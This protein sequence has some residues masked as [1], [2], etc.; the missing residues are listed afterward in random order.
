MYALTVASGGF[1]LQPSA[2]G[3]CEP[4]EPDTPLRIPQ[5]PPPGWIPPCI[6]H[7][8]W[9]G[10]NWTM[11]AAEQQIGN[12]AGSLGG[13]VMDRPVLDK[14]GITGTY[15]FQIK[16]AHDATTPGSLPAGMPSPFQPSGIPLAPS[17]PSVLEQQLGL[18]LTPDTGLREYIVVESAERPSEN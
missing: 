7:T 11:E 9:E 17:L 8:G 1:K 6:M 12:F 15:T 2:P 5:N 13:A 4:H 3:A 14:T 16:F 18:T 10:P